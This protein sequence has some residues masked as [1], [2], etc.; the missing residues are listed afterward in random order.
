[1]SRAPLVRRVL[2]PLRGQ[3]GSA[4]VICFISL[5]VLSIMG[6]GLLAVAATDFAVTR[7]WADYS[8]AFY[9]A[10]AGVEAGRAGLWTL[11]STT[12]SP[13]DSDLAGV[14]APP[15]TFSNPALS[16]TLFQVQRGQTTPPF[17]SNMVLA[18]GPW[19][20][21]QGLVTPYLVRSTVTSTSGARADLTQGVQYVAVPLF[22]FGVFYGRGVDLEMAP[23]PAMTFNGRI[24]SN[25]NIYVGAGA[26]LTFDSYMTTSG[27]IYRQIKSSSAL[28]WGNNP[29]ILDPNGNGHALNFDHTYQPGFSSTWTADL[30]QTQALS[31]FGGRVKDSAMG[32]TDIIPPVPALFN[33]PSNPDQ[34]AHQLIEM[35]QASDSPALA[36]AK[37]YNQA[38][39]RIVDGTATNQA[40]QPV[41][42][43]PGAVTPC[44]PHCPWD[45]REGRTMDVL[46]ID[47]GVLTTAGL[48]PAN[49]V[50]YLGDSSDIGSNKAFRLVN[51]A[52][53]PAQGLTVVSQN[54]MYVQGDYNTV[55][56]VPAAILG[57]A[58]TVLSNNWSPNN[59]D[60]KGN[61][62]VGSR[63]ATST[64][65][66]AAFALAPSTESQLG[67]GNGQLENLIRFLENWTGQTFN[68]N[69]S[70]VALWHSQRATGA[71]QQPGAYYNPPI[72]NWTYDPLFNTTPPPGT[73]QG[74][75]ITRGAWWQN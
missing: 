56:R 69:G 27:N 48:M 11:L 26:T 24:H 67:H 70:L 50:V 19:A 65:V 36:A 34:I 59:S 66:N 18:S 53:L 46:N 51:G 8:A 41:G 72:R 68:Y 44:A 12:P 71:W 73:P 16:F 47:V 39:L 7:N 37:L 40:G 6:L 22:Q 23:G 75:L 17:T 64:T 2:R 30:W 54:P 63:P 32:I 28:P 3:R 45:G 21:L 1:M 31:T 42:L 61:Q 4:L 38:G 14:T 33:D 60:D 49:G 29:T 58:I 15:P 20:G 55:N 10:D 35:P 9:A 52:S 62:A 57:D 5:L 43:P 74:V 13:S 25:S